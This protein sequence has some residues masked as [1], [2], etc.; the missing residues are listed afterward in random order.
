MNQLSW[1]GLGLIAALG[2][3]GVAVLGKIG[4][5]GVDATTA[6]TLR[7]VV[8]TVALLAVFLATG[9]LGT[10]RMVDGRAL[11]FIVLAALSGAISWLAYFA[12]LRIGAATQVASIDRLSLAFVL[13]LSAAFLGER[14]GWR[15]WVGIGL[16]VVGIVLVAS[17]PTPRVRAGEAAAATGPSFV[18]PT[19]GV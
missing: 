13:L 7:S 12:A 3:A 16:V 5:T 9:R 18:A 11:T 8:M 2:G 17:D 6:T 19:S 14:Y 4:L 1:L 15:G 10:V